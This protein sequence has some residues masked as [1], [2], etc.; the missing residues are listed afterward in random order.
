MVFTLPCKQGL[1]EDHEHQKSWLF[2][3]LAGIL[4]LCGM[5]FCI[6]AGVINWTTCFVGHQMDQAAEDAAFALSCGLTAAGLLCFCTIGV[7][8][9][10]I[11]KERVGSK[12]GGAFM[13]AAI[14]LFLVLLPIVVTKY[15]QGPGEKV[16]AH[17][18]ENGMFTPTAVCA[19][20]GGAAF[21]ATAL[22]KPYKPEIE[23]EPKAENMPPVPVVGNRRMHRI[24]GNIKHERKRHQERSEGT[25]TAPPRQAQE[26]SQ[27]E[28]VG[29][30]KGNARPST[31]TK[32]QGT[33]RENSETG[34]GKEQVGNEVRRRMANHPLQ[35]LLDSINA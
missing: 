11:S 22:I 16:I 32:V 14:F 6:A 31:C 19:A 5:G 29:I 18:V 21:V 15:E 24:F 7:Y 26:P 4:F 3:L 25:C 34:T 12:L 23:N 9:N 1:Q 20:V 27:L 33:I 8:F 28:M 30:G 13:F 35:R 17:L 2:K 10:L